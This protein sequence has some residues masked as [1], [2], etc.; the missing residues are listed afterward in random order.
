MTTE[1]FTSFDGI[2]LALHRVG[3]GR[4]LVLLHGLFSS[5]QMNWI[6]WGHD[7]AI[8][9]LGYEVL[10]LDFRV[11]GDSASPRAPEAYPPNVLVRDVAALVG[12]LGLGDYDLG[13]F[14]LGAR[15]SLHGVASGALAPQRL[16]VGG[17]GT[18]GLGEWQ[19]RAAHF[20]RVIDEF[21]TIAR[22]DPAYFS[23]QFLKSQGVDRVAARLLLDTMPDLDLAQLANVAMPVLVVCGDE[24]CDNGSAEELA[25]LLPD[26]T[27]VEVP[28]THMGSVT[29]P[30][31][32]RAMAEW[33]GP[34]Q[35]AARRL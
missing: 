14:S 16:I 28:G 33:L 1:R 25:A 32:G 23:V 31:L 4:P 29:K 18:A 15:T 7:R 10:M 27:Y 34:A 13:G 24:D 30:D 11:H 21:D 20:K 12:H 8:A 35:S 17:M 3:E 22:G 26:A 2:E 9:E 5:A 6:K 19:K